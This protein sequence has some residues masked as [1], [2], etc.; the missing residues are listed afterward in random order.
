VRND[1]SWA[2]VTALPAEQVTALVRLKTGSLALATSNPGRV[3]ALEAAPG[4]RGTFVSRPKDTETVSSW[5][6][7]RWEAQQAAGTEIQIQPRSGNTATPD[8]TWTDWSAPYAKSE[9]EAI[10]SERARFLQ[11]KVTLTGRSG[12]TPVLDSMTAAYLP[13]NLRPTVQSI[14]VHPP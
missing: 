5:G 6:R 8:A 3:F 13:R 4:T 12:A 1:R 10:T 9:G 7:L 14:T 2:M 11:V